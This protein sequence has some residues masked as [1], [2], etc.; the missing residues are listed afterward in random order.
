MGTTNIKTF[1]IFGEGEQTASDQPN[2]CDCQ[3]DNKMKANLKAGNFVW[4][5]LKDGKSLIVYN[6][7]L[8]DTLNIG[9]QYKRAHVLWCNNE[10]SERTFLKLNDKDQYQACVEQPSMEDD[11]ISEL[12][13][14]HDTIIG[15]VVAHNLR[16]YNEG[17]SFE[18]RE[19]SIMLSERTSGRGKWEARGTLYCGYWKFCDDNT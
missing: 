10:T 16:K 12:L 14:R 19:I 2:P 17:E 18:K 1:A 5:P 3:L 8:T 7:N 4:F 9:K 6:I 13:T 11:E 15:Q